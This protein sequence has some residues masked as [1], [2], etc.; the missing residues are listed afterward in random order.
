MTDKELKR[1]KEGLIKM[2]F[3]KVDGVDNN[4]SLKSIYEIV[5]RQNELLDIH[6]S[7]FENL[8]DAITGF[9]KSNT[10]EKI[11]HALS[12]ISKQVKINKN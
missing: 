1:E 7:K 8:F 9:F 11:K 5:R 3:A 2:L 4:D 10:K 6:D 12:D